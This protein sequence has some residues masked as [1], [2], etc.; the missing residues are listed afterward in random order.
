MSESPAQLRTSTVE[1]VRSDHGHG[2]LTGASDGF[3]GGG[4]PLAPSRMTGG[5][6]H[7]FEKLAPP[8]YPP[9]TK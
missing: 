2:T 6:K 5:Q 4:D 9:K 3:P 7:L 8:D 1:G